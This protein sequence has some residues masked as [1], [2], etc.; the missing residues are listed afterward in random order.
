MKKKTNKTTK[1]ADS[2]TQYSHWTKNPH[3]KLE[4][5]KESE[6]IY[7]EQVN[8]VIKTK[9]IKLSGGVVNVYNA[10]F[11]EIDQLLDDIRKECRKNGLSDYACTNIKNLLDDTLKKV[12]LS[13]N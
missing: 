7:K 11:S 1:G 8:R 12:K 10:E 4:S 5:G 9:K 3:E 13:Q 2:G 6:K